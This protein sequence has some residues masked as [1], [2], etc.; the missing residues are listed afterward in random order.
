MRPLQS[1]LSDTIDDDVMLRDRL[2]RLVR[3]G[4]LP[5]KQADALRDAIAPAL[6]CDVSLSSRGAPSAVYATLNKSDGKHVFRLDRDGVLRPR[7]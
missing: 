7:A 5:R 1:L 4:A 2:D 6:P 3:W